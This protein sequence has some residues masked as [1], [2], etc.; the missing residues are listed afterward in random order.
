MQIAVRLSAGLARDAGRPRHVVT[1]A[2]GATVSD[3]VAALTEQ[4]PILESRLARAVTIVGGRQVSASALL[5]EGQELAFLLPVAGGTT[6][7]PIP[8]KGTNHGD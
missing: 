3:A 7:R 5:H 4:F 1:V 8:P 6:A 2:E